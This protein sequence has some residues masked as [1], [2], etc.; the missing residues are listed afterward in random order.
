M[1]PMSPTMFVFREYDFF[2][3]EVVAGEDGVPAMLRGHYDNGRTDVSER[4]E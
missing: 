4:T 3:L 1:Y 2:R